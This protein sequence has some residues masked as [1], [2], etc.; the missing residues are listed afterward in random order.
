MKKALQKTDAHWNKD[1]SYSSSNFSNSFTIQHHNVNGNVIT[2]GGLPLYKIICTGTNGSAKKTLEA[3]IKLKYPSIFDKALH[4]CDGITLDGNGT[5]QSYSSSESTTD[6]QNGD[7]GTSNPNANATFRGDAVIKGN[8]S[9][10]GNIFSC[11]N[12][13]YSWMVFSF[14]YVY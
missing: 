2:S 12:F 7:V 8:I 6:G 3:V 5:I 14:T 4:G 9:A 10:A 1:S 13:Y 11:K